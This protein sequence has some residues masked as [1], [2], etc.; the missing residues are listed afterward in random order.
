M[1]FN[2]TFDHSLD[3]K[4]RLTVPAKFRNDLSGGVYVTR[5]QADCLRV[6][7][8]DTYLELVDTAM[9]GVNPLSRR[10]TQL[11][12]LFFTLADEVPLD[13][14]GRITL[15]PRQL[16]HAGISDRDVIVSGVGRG[17]ELWS[18]EKWAQSE[19]DLLANSD[20]LTDS[21]DHA[22]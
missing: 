22:G 16:A 8:R 10:A 1:H 21:L 11:N 7:P 20:E 12:R 14:A 17:L 15:T 18:P 13:G 2:G 6:F 9:K 4:N 3:A 19:D 5:N